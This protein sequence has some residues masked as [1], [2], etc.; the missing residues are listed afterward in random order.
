MLNFI[1]YHKL[2]KCMFIHWQTFLSYPSHSM[3]FQKDKKKHKAEGREYHIG[4]KAQ[5][6]KTQMIRTNN[7][8]QNVS[9]EGK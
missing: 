2:Q 7:R 5:D 3:G 4:Q 1:K 8:G 9:K 6:Y